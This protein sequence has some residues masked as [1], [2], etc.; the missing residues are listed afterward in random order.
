MKLDIKLEECGSIGQ[1]VQVVFGSEDL[2]ERLT[3]PMGGFEAGQILLQEAWTQ[4]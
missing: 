2:R 3:A 1:L 4:D